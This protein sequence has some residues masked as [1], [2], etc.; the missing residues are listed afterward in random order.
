MRAIYLHY[1]YFNFISRGLRIITPPAAHVVIASIHQ[2]ICAGYD[3][4]HHHGTGPH[5]CGSSSALLHWAPSPHLHPFINRCHRFILLLDHHESSS[6]PE[7]ECIL[8][9]SPIGDESLSY[10]RYG[11]RD[12]IQA[13]FALI[14]T[15][16][17][18]PFGCF[19]LLAPPS[20]PMPPLS[21]SAALAQPS[22]AN[23]LVVRLV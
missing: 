6:S 5:H 22:S 11:P 19:L 15:H 2:F 4:S 21:S 20:S 17:R 14:L 23:Q 8:N 7:I 12:L 13:P 9:K 16:R 3:Y 18:F 1:H 10:E